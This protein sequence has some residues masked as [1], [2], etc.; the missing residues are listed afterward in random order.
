MLL[1]RLRE[2]ELAQT[3][4][5]NFEA[6]YPKGE[7]VRKDGQNYRVTRYVWRVQIHSG[8]AR[9]RTLVIVKGVHVKRA[10]R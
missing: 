3:T 4:D 7:L 5:T 8:D 1:N 6:R 2:H 10:T 9:T